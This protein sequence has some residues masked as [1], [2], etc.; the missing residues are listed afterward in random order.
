MVANVGLAEVVA[1]YATDPDEA[2]RMWEIVDMVEN[3]LG[4]GNEIA[5][6]V[7]AILVAAAA[8]VTG[9]FSR[10]FGW[11]SLVIGDAGLLTVV[12]PLRDVAGALFGLGYIVWFVWV[13]IALLRS[14]A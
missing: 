8:L 4:G 5:G 12:P 10:W 7:W 13:G 6:G 1:R 3:G 11:F 2:V 9:L 14:R